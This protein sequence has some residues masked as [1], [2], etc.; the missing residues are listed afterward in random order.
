M[1][2][3]KVLLT[4]ITGFIGRNLAERLERNGCAITALIRPGTASSRLR[5]FADRPAVTISEV[6]LTDTR[7]LAIH[8]TKGHWDVIFHIAAV[9]GGRRVSSQEY[10]RVNVGTTEEIGRYARD[11]STRL[12]FCSSVGVYGAVP[13]TLPAWIGT[14]LRDDNYYHYT[15]IEA[16]RRLQGLVQ[17]GLDCVML[18]PAITYGAGDY[19]FP[20]TLVRLVDTGM[21]VLPARP[22]EIH[23]ADVDMLCQAF[24]AAA[25]K[26]LPSGS[27][28]NVA[29]RHPVQLKALADFI[30]LRLRGTTYPG[31]KRLPLVAFRVGEWITTL[32][33]NELWKARF[34]LI[35]R[36]WF[37]E[38]GALKTELGV[39]QPN[40][41]PA[42]EKVISWYRSLR[43]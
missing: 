24:W 29:D 35:S 18:R 10:F 23:L 26:S 8:L 37:Y 15:K 28:Y 21:L 9:R 20:Y 16:E 19:G 11:H 27:V 43:S 30:H 22:V 5:Q 3:K 6:D 39:E 38:V 7:A 32:V 34:E 31:W 17:E 33:R 36:S 40:T 14:A 1:E 12:I 4:G 41:I 25:L 42:F 2:G 13:S